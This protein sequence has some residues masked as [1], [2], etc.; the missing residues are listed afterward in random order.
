MKELDGHIQGAKRARAYFREQMGAEAEAIRAAE[1]EA[2]PVRDYPRGRLYSLT[3]WTGHGW[4]VRLSCLW[5]L[6]S[7]EHFACARHPR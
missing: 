1:I 6:L 3:C 5:S 7:L 4:G 2:L